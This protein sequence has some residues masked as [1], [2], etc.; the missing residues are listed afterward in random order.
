MSAGEYYDH[1]TYPTTGS[2][3]ASSSLRT[4][5]DNIEAG[6]G[7]LP[8]LSGNGSKVVAVNSGGTALEAITTTG[9]GNGVRATSPTFTTPVLGVATATTVNKITWTTPASGATVTIADGKTFT[10][11]N[12][13]TFTG[14]D[15]SSVAFGAGGTVAYTAAKLSAFSATTSAELAGVISDETGSGSLVFGTSPTLTTPTIGVATATSINKVAITA[16][17]T[18]ATLN[19]ADG[20]TLTASNTLTFTG[21]D[22]SS[23]AFGAGGTVT[24]AA[25]LSASSGSSLVGHI[26]SGTGAVA[27]TV[28]T[29]LRETVSTEDFG[30]ATQAVAA[31][32]LAGDGTLVVPNNVAPTLPAAHVET[33][34]EYLSRTNANIYAEGG[35]TT[36]R[37][38]RL[39]RSQDAGSHSGFQHS[40]M[41]IEHRPT[42]SGGNGAANADVAFVVSNVK[43]SWNDSGVAASGE[44]DGVVVF[45]AN[46]GP[47]TGNDVAAF[48]CDVR[49]LEGSG[50]ACILEGSSITTDSAGATVRSVR[51]QLGVMDS[52]TSTYIGLA[53][54]AESGVIDDGIRL[55]SSGTGTFT[56]FLRFLNLAG[57]AIV[58]MDASGQITTNATAA[59]TAAGVTVKSSGTGTWTNYFKATNLAGVDVFKVDT[60][61]N[62]ILTAPSGATPSK[63][64]RVNS[65][66]L[67]VVNDASS[68]Q[69]LALSDGGGLSLL[70]G[71]TIADNLTVN[72]G[73]L[74]ANTAGRGLKVKEGSNARMGVAVL[75]GGTI[76]VSNTSVTA[77]TRIFLSRSTTGGTTGDLSYTLIAATSFTINS[78]NAADTSTINWMLVEPA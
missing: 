63:K 2:F 71:A 69:I 32:E 12:T 59:G 4:E 21:T 62:I 38:R 70:G 23:V 47:G 77:N 9:T 5:L 60:T 65:G 26:A 36:R 18:S 24:Y 57:T 53:V 22:S 29:K 7:K 73:D 50:F 52:A 68:L 67:T 42:G 72:T 43:K 39:F 16:P 45:V 66:S 74:I 8:D 19:I 25:A 51:P 46:G 1:T 78:S 76:A 3:G 58:T 44:I 10:V 11:S 30:T 48:L 37:V 34:V 14:T 75:V 55:L 6:F 56:N 27:T 41:G 28:Q 64:I 54:I 49:S 31:I 33:V 61:G 15:A 13:L 40:V 17:A 20:K 35:E